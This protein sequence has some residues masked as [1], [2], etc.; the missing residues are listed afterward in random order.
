MK[1]DMSNP[2]TQIPGQN[3]GANLNEL[4]EKINNEV[5]TKETNIQK[6]IDFCKENDEKLDK[7]IKEY[8]DILYS[9]KRNSVRRNTFYKILEQ[10]VYYL[11]VASQQIYHVTTLAGFRIEKVS[12]LGLFTILT[13]LTAAITYTT[14]AWIYYKECIDYFDEKGIGKRLSN[15]NDE[16]INIYENLVALL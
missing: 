10:G 15:L 1:S 6:I 9:I 4:K 5:T 13:E 7:I 12:D 2:L 14:S 16:V 11:S 3:A 8:Y